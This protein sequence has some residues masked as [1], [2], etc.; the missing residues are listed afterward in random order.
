MSE[1]FGRKGKKSSISIECILFNFFKRYYRCIDVATEKK[2]LVLKVKNLDKAQIDS[3]DPPKDMKAF[4]PQYVR[5][6]NPERLFPLIGHY[7]NSLETLAIDCVCFCTDTDDNLD[8]MESIDFPYL[9]KLSIDCKGCVEATDEHEEIHQSFAKFIE[10]CSFPEVTHLY[11]PNFIVINSEFRNIIYGFP[12]LKTLFTDA[13]HLN[14]YRRRQPQL[15]VIGLRGYEEKF[16]KTFKDTLIEVNLTRSLTREDLTVLL[17]TLK[18]LKRLEFHSIEINGLTEYDNDGVSDIDEDYDM[19]DYPQHKKLEILKV[20]TCI[21]EEEFHSLITALPSLKMLVI[22]SS[23][24][25]KETIIHIGR[26][27]NIVDYFFN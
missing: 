10:S 20:K 25:T 2:E 13:S 26:I 22:K 8:L 11:L 9:K 23:E 5:L 27:E 7:A 21:F 14:Y 16:I 18:N 12:K 6:N 15:E 19:Y 24:V 3:E 1:I 4:F 17:K